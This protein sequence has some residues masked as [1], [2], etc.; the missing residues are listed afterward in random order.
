MWP[1]TTTYPQVRG[2]DV[3]GQTFDYIIVGG[4]TSGC[5]LA[6]RLSE[7]P[8][9]T[10][11]VLEKGH[12]NDNLYSRIPLMS[13]N[14][15]GPFLQAMFRWSEPVDAIAG[16]SA[17]LWT[18]EGVGGATRING[19]LVTRGAP[20]GYKAWKNE[21]GLTDWGWESLEPWFRGME[22]AVGKEKSPWRGQ[23]GLVES[24]QPRPAFRVY[25]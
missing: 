17:Q 9:V 23:S 16:R 25:D 21:F 15:L 22:K 11:L 13:Q 3:D 10:V 6:R 20:A 18:A 1:F 12:V 14:M 5:V 2:S 7:D 24:R 8:S 19:G 4:G